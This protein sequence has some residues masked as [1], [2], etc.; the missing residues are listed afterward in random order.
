MTEV[1]IPQAAPA[2]VA[3]PELPSVTGVASLE[4][5][6]TALGHANKIANF[7]ARSNFVPAPL[8]LKSKNN[9]KTTEELA[10]DVTAIILAGASIGYDPFQA[11]Q[12]M[13]IVHGSPA[14]YARSMVALVK[15]HGHKLDQ[16][17]ANAESV[18]VRARH[19]NE[20]EWHEFTWDMARA[21]K[22]G[23]TSN[24]KYASNPQE[25]LYAKAATEACR[26]MF[27]EVLA[28]ISAYSVEESELEDMGE[29]QTAAPVAAAA[30]PAKAR[31]QRRQQPVPVLPDVVHDAPAVAVEPEPEDDLPAMATPE[32][33]THLV[34]AL[35]AAGHST[36]DAKAEAVQEQVGRQLGGFQD[37][38]EAEA[39]DLIEFFNGAGPQPVAPI[40]P[41]AD[42][43]AAWLAGGK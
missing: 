25:M 33:I 11:V 20:T 3:M 35:K 15:S 1:S 18:T 42:A 14:M 37:L 23:Y 24:P 19:K 31:V 16:T 36:N 21:K 17:V 8:R 34:V 41:D 38:T 39:A 13:F 5:W 40:D 6:V 10:L 43:D 27:P 2:A 22:A 12:Q 7:M 9:Y 30:A 32:Q 29:L 28:G 4:S 26:R